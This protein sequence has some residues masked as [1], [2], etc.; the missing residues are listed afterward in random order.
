MTHFAYF[1]VGAGLYSGPP[2][3]WQQCLFRLLVG[4]ELWNYQ[5]V[6]ARPS[7]SAVNW[8]Q[9]A[10]AALLL[11]CSWHQPLVC[12]ED[13]SNGLSVSSCVIGVMTVCSQVCMDAMNT[14]C[15]M[16]IRVSGDGGWPSSFRTLPRE[17][18]EVLLGIIG[19]NAVLKVRLY[20][21]LTHA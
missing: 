17:W 21:A 9:F 4:A 2:S 11:L 19:F 1:V 13:K 12:V 18:R 6:A 15:D 5:Y 14:A 3:S 20:A 7:A 10:A 8:S 16:I